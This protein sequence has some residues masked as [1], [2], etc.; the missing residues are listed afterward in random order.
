MKIAGW[1]VHGLTIAKSDSTYQTIEK[2]IN[3]GNITQK[4]LQK[5]TGHRLPIDVDVQLHTISFSNLY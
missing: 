1:D 3:S 2:A 4:Y 5:V